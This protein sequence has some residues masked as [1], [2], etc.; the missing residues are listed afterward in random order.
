MK[1]KNTILHNMIIDRERNRTFHIFNEENS[2]KKV[3][4]QEFYC[5]IATSCH[6]TVDKQW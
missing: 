4:K 3:E 5:K 6:V 1:K 2:L